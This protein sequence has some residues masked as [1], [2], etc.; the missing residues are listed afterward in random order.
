M[1]G[2]SAAR[3]DVLILRD[4]F[5]LIASRIKSNNLRVKNPNRTVVELWIA[6]AKEYLGET[7]FLKNNKVCINYNQWFSDVE[8]RKYLASLLDVEFSDAGIN[9]VKSQGG[10]SSFEGQ[11]LDGQATKMQVLDRWE[12]FADDSLFQKWLNNRELISY[13]ERILGT[14]QERKFFCIKFQQSVYLSPQTCLKR[15]KR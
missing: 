14:Y 6:Y 15:L 11:E 3:Y 12:S 2:K 8:Y 10:G 5:N 7:N 13:S 1:F 4:P 9:D